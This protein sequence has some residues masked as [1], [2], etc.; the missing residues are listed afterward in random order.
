[1]TTSVEKVIREIRLNPIVPSESV[2]VAT[3]RGMRPKKAEEPAPRDTRA[4]VDS[5]PFC[6]GNEHMTPPLIAAYPNDKNWEIRIV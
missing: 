4:H 2:L 5:C 3:A 1:M 6:V